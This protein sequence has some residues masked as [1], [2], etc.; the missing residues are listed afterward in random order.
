LAVEAEAVLL[1]G[2][3]VWD[4]SQ[5]RDHAAG[6]AYLDQAAA[7][8]RDVR[9]PVVLG[10]ALL[11][12]AIVALY[13]QEDPLAG[14]SL[15]RQA[16]EA[17]AGVSAVLTGLAVLHAAEAHAMVGQRRECEDALGVAE[18]LLGQVSAMDE[19]IHLF[20]PSQYA[21]MAG[22]CYLTLGLPDAAESTLRDAVAS[23]S[24]RSKSHAIVLGN[25]TLAQVRQRNFD[26]AAA[27]FGA[28]ID[29]VT[30]TWGGGGLTVLFQAGRELR[31]GAQIP[32]VRQACD[33]LLDIMSPMGATSQ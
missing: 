17:V 15:A 31:T 22:S 7:I 9:M 33:R 16:A 20:S 19:A 10:L 27:T 5:R 1:M 23:Q 32:H 2:Q 14:L 8:A 29:T 11:R 6:R 13:G 4:A 26:E 12:S 21:R 30:E 25:L 28:A 3:L 24:H 18:S